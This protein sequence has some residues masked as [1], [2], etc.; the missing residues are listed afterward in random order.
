MTWVVAH[1]SPGAVLVIGD[2]R[3]SVRTPQGFQE[4]PEIGVKKVHHVLPNIVVGFAGSIGV[5]F[6]MVEEL[7]QF[8]SWQAG[9][10][11]ALTLADAWCEYMRSRYWGLLP[12]HLRGQI[13]HLIV[14]G[15]HP[16]PVSESD[17]RPIPIGV[18]AI[19]ECPT[20]EGEPMKVIQ[21]FGAM[22]PAVS[23]GSGSEV[24][25]YKR[26]LNEF[27]WLKVSQFPDPHLA[28]GAIVQWTIDRQPTLG[29]SR[30]VI[31]HMLIGYRDGFG[32]QVVALGD[33]AQDRDRVA[34]A[35]DELKVLLERRGELPTGEVRG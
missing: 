14:A 29:V 30:D 34:V 4:L 7:R 12:H 21:R 22:D 6:R 18:G 35:P 33:H 23:I 10:V 26:L 32:A 3:I 24:E 17:P 1:A 2:V 20:E 8:Y 27:D 11:G 5:G 16:S 25:E 19:I 15:F 31:G 13:T 9:F 28:V